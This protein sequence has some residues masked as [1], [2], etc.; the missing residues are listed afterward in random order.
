MSKKPLVTVITGNSNCG[1]AC[2]KE[3]LDTYASKVRVRGVFRSDDKAAQFRKM[4]PELEIVSN[5]DATQPE[6]LVNAFEGAQAAFIVHPVDR[7]TNDFTRDA[8]YS[9][10]MI[11]SAVENG[12]KNIVYVGSM[13]VVEPVKCSLISSRFIPSE[14]LLR[15]LHE[16][17]K[18]KFTVLRCTMFMDNFKRF[19][20]SIKAESAFTFPNL[21][22]PYVD[23]KDVGRC[24]ALC[25]TSETDEHD[26]KFYIVC[27]PQVLTPKKIAE[28]FS[29]VI[30]KP[31]HYNELKKETFQAL[32]PAMCQAYT[33]FVDSPPIVYEG[34]L[35][36]LIGEVGT[37][38]QFVR[39]HLH[40]FGTANTTQ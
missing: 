30:G 28:I 13:S 34:D 27:G 36:K 23:T 39:D 7:S 18:I 26:G 19:F 12:V 20:Q 1:S 11:N 35:P 4:F 22:S 24:A 40:F 8:P 14:N 6:T 29:Q 15:K 32:P 16:E 9:L 5:V 2:I 31:V 33:N 38:E 3:L 21:Q 25:L 17:K 37:F 10:N